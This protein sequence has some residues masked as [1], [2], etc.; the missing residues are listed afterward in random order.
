MSKKLITFDLSILD[1]HMS[2]SGEV[3]KLLTFSIKNHAYKLDFQQHGWIGNLHAVTDDNQFCISSDCVPELSSH[4]LY[5]HGH[6]TPLR[7]DGS[8]LP[9]TF[10]FFMEDVD[11]IYSVLHRINQLEKYSVFIAETIN[12]IIKFEKT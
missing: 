3:Y 2:E 1:G 4:E 9:T 11:D 8:T 5:L 7:D 6:K 10:G 12:N